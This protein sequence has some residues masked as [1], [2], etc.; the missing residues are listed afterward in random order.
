M[1]GNDLDSESRFPPTGTAPDESG[2]GDALQ[3]RLLAG[4]SRTF[5]LTIPQLPPGL[6]GVVA[7]AYLLCRIVDTIE[8][9]PVLELADKEAHCQ[10]FVAALQG[11]E[12]PATFARDLGDRLTGAET[13]AE[14]E[15]VAVAPQII[16]YTRSLPKRQREALIACVQEMAAGMLEMQQ[17]SRPDGLTDVAMMDRYCYFVAGV[18]GEMLTRLFCDYS[19]AINRNAD[20]LMALAPSF[21]QGLQMTNILKDVWEDRARGVCWLP[22]DV[23][24][25]AGFD[26]A[27]LGQEGGNEPGFRDGMERLVAMAHGHLRN[28]LQYTLILPRGEHRIRNF[29]LWGVGMALLSL[30]NIH[31]TPGYRSGQEVKISRRSVRATIALCRLSA[32]H[33]RVVKGLF[34]TAAIGLPLDRTVLKDPVRVL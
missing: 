2:Q 10:R 14:R 18:V 26:L 24:N 31:R 16:G 30:Q 27:R 25:A 21:G 20:R 5:A 15:L 29:C 3:A 8:D 17:Q 6:H 7:N 34:R 22:R 9:D 19:P 23:F 1:T 11:R 4:V 33:D 28:A 12:N 13:A 32:S